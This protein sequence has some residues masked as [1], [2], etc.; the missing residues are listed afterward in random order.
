MLNYYL[1]SC[2]D[3]RFLPNVYE[4]YIQKTVRLTTGFNA[5][6]VFVKPSLQGMKFRLN[7]DTIDYL[8]LSSRI[9]DFDIISP[10]SFPF[11]VNINFLLSYNPDVEIFEPYVDVLGHTWGEIYKTRNEAQTT[12][13]ETIKHEN[14]NYLTFSKKCWWKFWQK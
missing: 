10:E 1:I 13:N 4:C 6:I 12:V 8:V 7:I 2:D 14:E 11:L 3:N 9:N 5:I